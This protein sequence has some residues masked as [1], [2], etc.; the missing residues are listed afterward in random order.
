M[1]EPGAG[2][3][4]GCALQLAFDLFESG[5]MEESTSVGT[6]ELPRESLGAFT[7]N[8]SEEEAANITHLPGVLVADI[9]SRVSS[10]VDVASAFVASRIFWNVAKTTSFRLKLSSRRSFYGASERAAWTRSVIAGIRRTMCSTQE[11]DLSG[12]PV[13][14]E[15]V[16]ELL[17]DLSSVEHL[18]LDDCQNLTSFVAGPL[19]MSI[20]TG[21]R[22]LSMQKC[23]RLGPAVGGILLT[24]TTADNCRLQ[25]LLLSL[26]RI[27]LLQHTLFESVDGGRGKS[28][29]T[30]LKLVKDVVSNRPTSSL[31]IL[32]LNNCYN[33]GP[34]ELATIAEACPSLEIWM[35][36]GSAR[37]LEAQGWTEDLVMPTSALLKA[38]KLLPRLRILEITS[39]SRL[40]FDEVRTKISPG[41]HVWNFFEKKSVM[42]A[43]SL[44]AHMKGCRMPSFGK[45]SAGVSAEEVVPFPDWCVDANYDQLNDSFA[46]PCTVE[47]TQESSGCDA[48]EGWD[49]STSDI[50]MAVKAGVNCSDN[51]TGTPLHMAS[52]CGDV[53]RVAKLLFIGASTGARKRSLAVSAVTALIEAAE[54]GHAEVCRLLLKDGADVLARNSKGE[55]PLYIAAFRGHSAALEVMLAHC[56]EHGIHWQADHEY[57]SEFFPSYDD[58]L[59]KFFP[60]E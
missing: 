27:T 40:V 36:G 5:E 28:L 32:A 55:T 26:H 52:A 53:D 30:Y 31:R 35:L 13:S 14:D 41:V 12:W 10:P 11:L 39:F 57:V 47:S 8:Q 20:M 6:L 50:L 44:V 42:A 51:W 15:G 38:A 46:E 3:E 45:E 7:G 21:L 1:I 25:T 16:A 24:A 22:A 56:H 34:S 43:V 9:L 54:K 29:S 58:S 60:F 49:I 59:S 48:W 23:V 19:S 17:V 2:P 33:I 37:G 4:R 18:V